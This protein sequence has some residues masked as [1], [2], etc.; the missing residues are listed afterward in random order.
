MRFFRLSLIVALV[1][2][3]TVQAQRGRDPSRGNVRG[4]TRRDQPSGPRT[5]DLEA[6]NPA[7]IAIERQKD[8]ELTASQA[9]RLDTIATA[10][11]LEAKDFGKAIDTLQNV[12]RDAGRSLMNN[13]KGNGPRVSRNPPTSTKDSISRAR[14]DSIDQA[15]ADRD[16]E[17][18]MAARNAL[19]TTLLK[20]RESYDARLIAID[21]LLTDD[22]RRKIGPWFES[23][24][25]ELT[26]RLHSANVGASGGR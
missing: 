22:Q 2:P 11:D 8:L 13:P 26:D 9:S 24:S 16:Q 7:R 19:A 23:A 3:A 21:A 25:T 15:N 12:M 20:I 6:L 5:K 17:R 4:N 18:Y 1:L 10:Y 14:N